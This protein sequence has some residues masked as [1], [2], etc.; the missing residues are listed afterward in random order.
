MRQTFRL[1]TFDFVGISSLIVPAYL[2]RA[3]GCDGIICIVIGSVAGFLYLALLG[4]IKNRM[5]CGMAPYMK[6]KLPAAV[7]ILVL[8]WLAVHCI[9][10]AG[11]VT[12]LFAELMRKCLI[13]GENYVVLVVLILALS[14]YAVSGGIEGRARVYEV[15]FWFL[16][17]PLIL[18]L[19]T[20]G[21]GTDT[22]NWTPLFQASF[23]KILKGSYLV[24]LFYGVAMWMLF[25]PEYVSEE[26]AKGKLSSRVFW[27]MAI[28]A[29]L[30]LVFYL[31]LLG[32]FGD[33]ALARMD[34][35]AVTL[36][37]TI[38]VSG[39][40][41]KRLDALMLS[42]WFF[43]L[44]ALLNL[45]MFYSANMMRELVEIKGRRRYL[46]VA[47]LLVLGVALLFGYRTQETQSWFF[48]YIW[49]AGTPLTVAVPILVWFIGKERKT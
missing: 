24:F 17:V 16:F 12:Y 47:A 8:L 30:L 26:D 37:S 35:P 22:A 49:Y 29:V 46:A 40:F 7:R 45:H 1:F 48:G 21:R 25:F 28:T 11:F 19:V 20:A 43:T 13:Q 27:A 31:I 3:A 32:N 6:R 23:L 38:Q 10:I 44:F 39:N 36:M 33:K 14:F 4:G 42:V 18:M 5:G 34:F 41:V 15:L 9:L 2:A